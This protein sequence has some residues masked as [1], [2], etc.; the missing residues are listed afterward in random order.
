MSIGAKRGRNER[1]G[2]PLGSSR[3]SNSAK[4]KTAEK[5][6]NDATRGGKQCEVQTQTDLRGVEHRILVRAKQEIQDAEEV[7]SDMGQVHKDKSARIEIEGNRSRAAGT[8]EESGR[9][10]TQYLGEN[11]PPKQAKPVQ[12]SMSDLTIEQ[13]FLVRGDNLV[14]PHTLYRE[15]EIDIVLENIKTSYKDFKRTDIM[16]P[17]YLKALGT[18]RKLLQHLEKP[19]TYHRVCQEYKEVTLEN[20]I[21]LLLRCR[22]A[23]GKIKSKQE[24]EAAIMDDGAVPLDLDLENQ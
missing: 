8:G 6:S 22:L 14:Q 18:L 16:R 17:F 24:K 15:N 1:Q 3:K 2:F 23:Y 10:F 4:R 20:T 21:K 5:G 12:N 13:Q 11:H 7:F 19:D 9:T